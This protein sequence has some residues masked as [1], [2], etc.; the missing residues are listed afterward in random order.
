MPRRPSRPKSTLQNFVGKRSVDTK[1]YDP[2]PRDPEPVDLPLTIRPMSVQNDAATLRLASG[3][4]LVRDAPPPPPGYRYTLDGRCIPLKE[5]QM[6]INDPAAQAIFLEIIE[7]TGSLRAACDAIG[8][9]NPQ[10]AIIH[11]KS[12]PT[13]A[14]RL[15]SSVERHRQTLYNAAYQ[16]AVHGYERPIVGG[17]NKDEIVAHERVYSDS[18][19]AMLLKR[20]FPEFRENSRN[21]SNPLEAQG[22]PAPPQQ[23][24]NRPDMR[25][26][27]RS[28]RDRIAAA[29]KNPP[30]QIDSKAIIDV[31]DLS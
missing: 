26:V 22:V 10:D 12:H 25:T 17:R 2:K 23:L 9:E 16:R 11:M 21:A 4:A 31:E 20:H 1:V 28:E 6:D 24:S 7:K 19:L 13:F 5:L 8:M 18:L 27:S 3:Q 30:K 29:I 14:S 15:E